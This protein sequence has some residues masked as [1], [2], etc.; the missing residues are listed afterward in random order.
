MRVVGR[1]PCRDEDAASPSFPVMREDRLV[2]A[3][4]QHEGTVFHA[5]VAELFQGSDDFAR[6]TLQREERPVMDGI[7]RTP[8]PDLKVRWEPIE[9]VLRRPVPDIFG[10]IVLVAFAVGEERLVIIVRHPA[11]TRRIAE[12]EAKDGVE[13]REQ[14]QELDIGEDASSTSALNASRD[15]G[16][17][18]PVVAF[19]RY[20]SNQSGTSTSATTGTCVISRQYTRA[21][22]Q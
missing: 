12:I 2:A 10:R 6:V 8:K 4:L 7:H 14:Y 9:H 13:A 19:E 11:L 16:T 22:L 21:F 20:Q 3:G 1:E 18:A 5:G 17:A 15:D